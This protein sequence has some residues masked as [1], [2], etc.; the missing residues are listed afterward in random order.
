MPIFSR[1]IGK[2]NK[3]P[4]LAVKQMEQH[5]RYI[6]EQLEFALT[7]L[8]SSNIKEIRTDETDITSSSGSTNFTGDAISVT[9][10]NGETFK[11]GKDAKSGRFIFEL[12]G[13]NGT[14][15]I[16]TNN[17]GQVVIAKAVDLS[18]DCGEW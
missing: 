12:K 4:V 7:N 11:V 14:Q 18:I 3:D 2:L 10:A 5:I 6:Q 13:K 17:D 8:D 15:F 9:G 1:Q 16:Y